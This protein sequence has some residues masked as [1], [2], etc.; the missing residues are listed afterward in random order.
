MC[1]TLV[2]NYYASAKLMPSSLMLHFYKPPTVMCVK[3][4]GREG[5]KE[6]FV[7]SV[8]IEQHSFWV[9]A[10]CRHN[11]SSKNI[12]KISLLRMFF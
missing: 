1:I 4:H 7:L 2:L 3:A 5:E 9:I 11:L 12:S 8:F 10:K 6:F